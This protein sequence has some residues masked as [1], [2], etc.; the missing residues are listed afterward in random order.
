MD[1]GKTPMAGWSRARHTAGMKQRLWLTM[2]FALAV[3]AAAS[4]RAQE[5]TRHAQDIAL[6]TE[7]SPPDEAGTAADCPPAEP[8]ASRPQHHRLFPLAAQGARDRGYR[9]PEPWGLGVLAVR[10]TTN[11]SSRDLQVAINKG[12]DP[13]PDAQL[14]PLPAVTTRRLQGKTDMIGFKADLWLLPGVNVFAAVG[15]VKGTNMIDVAID[16]DAVAPWPFC[17]P[18]KPCGTMHLPV[19]TRVN[20]TTMTFGTLLVYGNDRWFVMGSIAKTV[21]V[22]SKKRSDVTSTNIGMRAG[23][24]FKL[25]ESTFL[26]PYFGANYFDLD[27]TVKGI[28]TSGPAFEDGDGVHLR[29]QVE[30]S[31]RH[32]MAAVAG[33]SVELN[34]HLWLQAELQAGED[35]TRVLASSTVRF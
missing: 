7:C 22:S 11:F 14:L 4:A 15:K 9:I 1:P 20:N 23:P 17:R 12:V 8:P 26:A 27:T 28:V 29:Y 32:P 16:L 35:S 34:R 13:A 31:A 18:A 10:N 25:G 24:R 2:P 30:M 3:F 5:A 21:S 6:P 33:M 19:E